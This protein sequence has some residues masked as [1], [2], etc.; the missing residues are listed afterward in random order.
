MAC[1][2]KELSQLTRQTNGNTYKQMVFEATILGVADQCFAGFEA[3][4]VLYDVVMMY[5]SQKYPTGPFPCVAH[6]VSRKLTRLTQLSKYMIDK[7]GGSQTWEWFASNDKDKAC[8]AYI[9]I[10]NLLGL[11]M[12]SDFLTTVFT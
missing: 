8:T 11:Q 12:T 1:P 3:K 5:T 10:V 9:T 7:A 6:L 2:Q 4:D